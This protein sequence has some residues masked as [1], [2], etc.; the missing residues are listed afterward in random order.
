MRIPS[1]AR[2]LVCLFPHF[3]IA[4]VRRYFFEPTLLVDVKNDMRIVQEE[5]FG[6]VMAVIKFRTDEEVIAMADGTDYG[7]AMSVFAKSIKRAEH[8]GRSVASG[9][10][11]LNDFGTNYLMQSLPFGGVKG[12]GFGRF[13]GKEGLRA[14]C[15]TKAMTADLIPGMKT[16]VPPVLHYPVNDVSVRFS[17][18]LAAFAYEDTL[19]G[20]IKGLF[21]LLG[22]LKK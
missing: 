22:N 10:A 19:L 6:P 14:C 12:S 21:Q 11:N 17:N 18:A 20:R 7:L 16:V 1:A 3:R 5:V 4:S 15:Y 8:I 2:A 13:A 9:V